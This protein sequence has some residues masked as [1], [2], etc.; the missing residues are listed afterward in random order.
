MARTQ[1]TQR[2]QRLGCGEWC[3]W[4]VM[5]QGSDHPTEGKPLERH[6]RI[7][8]VILVNQNRWLRYSV[9]LNYQIQI[10]CD[11]RFICRCLVFALP[12]SFEWAICF[13]M[14]GWT[15]VGHPHG[16]SPC[17]NNNEIVEILWLEDRFLWFMLILFLY[18]FF[19][20]AFH[21]LSISYFQM[22]CLVHQ[23]I[24]NLPGCFWSQL[25]LLT[26]PLVSRWF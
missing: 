13:P 5:V 10:P 20:N 23:Y 16:L 9:G 1:T 4:R 15:T 7:G 17:P 3:L 22:C 11:W 24:L 14:G 26:P 8:S 19:V 12:T 21:F 6:R 25:V 2:T 18:S